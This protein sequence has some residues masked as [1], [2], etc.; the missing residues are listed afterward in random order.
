[1]WG[2]FRKHKAG[3]TT[4]AAP[5]LAVKPVGVR[6]GPHV[7]LLDVDWQVS[8]GTDA[9]TEVLEAWLPHGQFFGERQALH[10]VLNLAAGESSVIQRTVRCVAEPGAIVENGFLI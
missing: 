10:P 7:G 6:E 2:I 4:D 8:N 3:M 1:M 9:S 5:L